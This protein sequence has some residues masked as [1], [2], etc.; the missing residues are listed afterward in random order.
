MKN[1]AINRKFSNQHIDAAIIRAVE[2]LMSP[3]GF[4]LRS[5]IVLKTRLKLHLRKKPF[6]GKHQTPFGLYKGI[7]PME[8]TLFLVRRAKVSLFA[9]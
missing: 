1:I 9:D 7:K 4:P 2:R 5:V 3:K 8:S 6:F